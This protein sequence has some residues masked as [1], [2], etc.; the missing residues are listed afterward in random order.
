M[1]TGVPSMK[2]DMKDVTVLVDGDITEKEG[3][4]SLPAKRRHSC[5]PGLLQTDPANPGRRN[6]AQR[7][8]NKKE[9]WYPISI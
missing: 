2:R 8:S 4:I 7:Q 3:K 5:L 6:S 1:I 9:P